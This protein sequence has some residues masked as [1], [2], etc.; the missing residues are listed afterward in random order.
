MYIN[1]R[2]VVEPPVEEEYMCDE[3]IIALDEYALGVKNVTEWKE[4][5]V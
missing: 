1:T 3:R 4:Q 2:K 5:L